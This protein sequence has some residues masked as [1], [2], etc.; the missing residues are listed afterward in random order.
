MTKR[1]IL[2][3]LFWLLTLLWTLMLFGFSGQ[4][5]QESADLSILATQFV[6]RLFPNIPCSFDRLH[7][8]LRKLA[9]FTFFG[10]EGL[11][12]G[13]SLMCSLRRVKPAAC[14]ALPA[15]LAIAALNEYHQS[16]IDGRVASAMDVGIDFAGA[17]LGVGLAAALMQLRRRRN[18][19]AS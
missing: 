4:D 6:L 10:A 12:L 7:F 9:H 17:A 14:I 13:L 16:F 3:L 1:R 8:L 5:G 19:K 2:T 15:C 11:L 18:A